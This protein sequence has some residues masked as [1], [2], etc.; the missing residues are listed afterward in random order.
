MLEMTGFL[1]ESEAGGS[2][3]LQNSTPFW[4]VRN[5]R[6]TVYWRLF[7]SA[8]LP[9]AASPAQCSGPSE[10]ASGAFWLLDPQILGRADHPATVIVVGMHLRGVKTTRE[11]HIG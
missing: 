7:E 9:P 3:P 6:G 5:G 2:P 11:L 8:R 1:E 10:G 4:Q